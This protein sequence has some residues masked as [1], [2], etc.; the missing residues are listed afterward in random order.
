MRRFVGAVGLAGLMVALAACG[1]GT[2]GAAPNSNTATTPTSAA[3]SATPSTTAASPPPTG[4]SVSGCYHGNDGKLF[5]YGV[6]CTAGVR[7]TWAPMAGIPSPSPR[8]PRSGR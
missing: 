1:G 5:T 2:R 8:P 4:P 6:I 3:A 7:W